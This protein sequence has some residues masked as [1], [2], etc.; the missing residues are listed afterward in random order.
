VRRET[1]NISR[2]PFHILGALLMKLSALFV[3]LFLGLG[4]AI[5]G[6]FGH[7]W[8]AAWAGGIAG[9]AVIAAS[10]RRDWL[11]RLPTLTALAAIGWAVGGMMSYG[12]IVG[13]GRGNDFGNVLYGLAMLGVVGGLYGFIG[14][15]MFGLGLESSEEKKPDW[16]VLVTQMVAGGYLFWGIFIYQ[17][18]WLM[19]PPRSE[20]WAG[21]LGAAAALAW[22]LQRNGYFS[23]LRVAGYSCLGA[24][25]GFAIGNFFQTMGHASGVAINWWNV[26]EFTLGFFGGLAMSYAVFTRP[27]PEGRSAS[28]VAN[29]VALCF[30]LFALPATNLL[31][32][33]DTEQ[34][35]RL[36][37][38]TGIANPEAFASWHFTLGWLAIVVFGSTG[39]VLK[40]N[41]KTGVLLLFCYAIYYTFFSHIRKGFLAG[42]GGIQLEQYFYWVVLTAAAVLWFFI[43]DKQIPPVR[44]FKPDSWQRWTI[45]VVTALMIII[46]AAF[47]AVNSHG[48]MGGAHER[49]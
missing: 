41:M 12:I 42:A 16:A 14:G 39:L 4:W 49:F 38:R 35:I 3:A 37:D 18:E 20:L 31:H 44:D 1:K 8:G 46:I 21:C 27:W 5:R 28:K 2:L 13:Y 15:G 23:A 11:S 7:E 40:R 48:S 47:I 32:A 9:L 45:Y 24:G 6:H 33:F 22:Y 43:R 25:F 30:L 10:G 29:G 26:M 19:T 36:A 17:F 34:F